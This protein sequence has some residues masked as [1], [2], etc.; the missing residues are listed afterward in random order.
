M[1]AQTSAGGVTDLEFP[2]QSGVLQSTL[3][4]IAE[5]LRV[6]IELLPIE[7]SSL[8]KH[9]DRVGFWSS[10]RIE[11]GEALAE[12]QPAR[13][14]DKANQVS[15]LAAAVAVENIFARVDV[16]RRPGLRLL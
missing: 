2:D 15:A 6:V 12:R 8:L 16:K 1:T 7:S 13:Q 3:A 5:C 10:P 9:R 11:M 14:L 4:E